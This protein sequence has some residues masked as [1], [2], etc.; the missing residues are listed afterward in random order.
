MAFESSSFQCISA[1]LPL[2][3]A[4]ESSTYQVA[5]HGV[6]D[7]G[8]K[9]GLASMR[10]MRIRY[11]CAS[12]VDTSCAQRKTA[13]LGLP[14]SDKKIEGRRVKAYDGFVNRLRQSITSIFQVA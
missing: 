4:F 10:F 1:F 9:D 11:L 6:T 7:A 8:L 14:Q 12:D 3:M 13:I 5:T 2:K